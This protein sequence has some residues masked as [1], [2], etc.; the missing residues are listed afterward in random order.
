MKARPQ[1]GVGRIDG[2]HPFR[3]IPALGSVPAPEIWADGAIAAMKPVE[4]MMALAAFNTNQAM[5]AQIDLAHALARILRDQ[6]AIVAAAGERA[7][8]PGPIRS[9]VTGAADLQADYASTLARAA[10]A[11]GRRF[12]HLAFAFPVAGPFR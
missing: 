6:A 2:A 8:A 12:G 10:Q 11:L 7:F 4:A 1:D 3:S 9:A 5:T